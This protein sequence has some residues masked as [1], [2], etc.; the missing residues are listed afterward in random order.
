MGRA[1]SCRQTYET[2]TA[3]VVSIARVKAWRI[4]VIF[5]LPLD[6]KADVRSTGRTKIMDTRHNGFDKTGVART[7]ENVLDAVVSNRGPEQFP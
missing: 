7:H 3:T 1:E 4:L 6:E 2:Q 5:V